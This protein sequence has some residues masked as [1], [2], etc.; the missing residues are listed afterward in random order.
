MTSPTRTIL[1]SF[2]AAPLDDF[3]ATGRVDWR[4]RAQRQPELPLRRA[5]SRRHGR[6]QP[7]PRASVRPRSGS[8]ATT[9]TTWCVGTWTRIFS[10]TRRQ[11]ASACSYSDF[12]NAIVPSTPGRQLTFP[13]IQDGARSACRRPPRRSGC[14]SPTRSPW[15]A[16]RTVPGRRRVAARQGRASTS[17]CSARAASSSSRT[18]PSSTSTA[19]AR[20]TTTICCSRSRCEAASPTRTCSLADCNNSYIAVLRPGRLAGHAAADPEPR[21]CATRWTRTSRTS[22]ATTRSIPSCSRSCRATATRDMNNFGP[23]IGF[24]WT[25]TGG[26]FSVHGG[27]GIY[28][29][30]ITLEI[31]SLERGLDGRALP[32]EVRAG[33]VFFLD[34]STGALPPFA[35]TLGESVHRL[36]PAGR[37][38][39]GHQHHRQHACRTRPSSSSTSGIQRELPRQAALRVDVIHN[40][41]TH[42]IIGRPIGD[43]LQSRG[44][45]PDRVVNLESSVDT[46]L[47]RR[48]S[49]PSRSAGARARQL[50]AVLYPRARR[51]NYANDD[52]IPFGARPD[53]PE[54]PASRSTAPRPTS[55]ATASCS[56]AR[57]SCPG[58][59]AFADLDHRVRRAHGH[60]DARRPRR[61]SRPCSA[62][63]AA[64]VQDRGRTQ[65]LPRR[66]ERR[67]RRSDGVPLPLVS[68]RRA[69]QRRVQLA[70]PARVA[71]ASPSARA[72]RLEP[73]VEVL[74]R[75]QRHQ[76]PRRRRSPTTPGFT[77]VLVRDSSDP[78]NPGYL[79]SSSIRAARHH[80]GRRLRLAAGR[81]RSS[82]A[83]ALNF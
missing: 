52:Q 47:R 22:P 31:M 4:P 74:Q 16:A 83:C 8:G 79:R 55:S 13:S 67:R 15:S 1:R 64:G 43:G 2:A 27:Y 14:S 7:R 36:H 77:N 20:S 58:P 18:S 60:P 39:V 49:R 28:Y 54:R 65:R 12:D 5:R 46:Q 78:S 33:N 23:R 30:R 32:I 48:C 21:A 73:I 68:R 62:T 59:C 42:F 66:A 72:S 51:C 41:G 38:R 82:S 17:G 75:V 11:H 57:S 69:L 19:T 24:D 61:A 6:Q 44:G 3:L 29:D 76:H 37:G 10:P 35:P 40:R 63:R 81:G 80:R 71:A 26:G 25:S 53:R 45:R 56:R 9:S 50:R 34:P 70:R